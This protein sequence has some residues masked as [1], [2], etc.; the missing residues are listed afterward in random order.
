MVDEPT[1]PETGEQATSATAAPQSFHEQLPEDLRTDPTFAKFTSVQDLAQSYQHA[2]RMVGVKPDE[3]VRL[4]AQDDDG[5][6]QRA[7]LEKLGL[8]TEMDVYKLEPIEGA[9]ETLGVDQ[10]LANGFREAAFK[11]GVLPAQAQA[12][13]NWF[14]EQVTTATEAQQTAAND[15]REGDEAALKTQW[16]DAFNAR[17]AAARYAMDQI[18][19]EGLAKIISDA[20]LDVNPVV[21]ETFAKL[22]LKMGENPAQPGE[23]AA[24]G[25]AFGDASTPGEKQARANDLIQQASKLTDVTA[26]MRL[27]Q[28][29]H[30]LMR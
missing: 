23:A 9:P 8:P 10:P 25:N 26:R 29:A 17:K 30:D 14:A 24:P 6:G 13:Y 11:A 16:G 21:M 20:G 2:Q 19:G 1:A 7:V 3:M 28:Q 18:G 15:Q 27:V 12:I 5:T 22:G 4:P